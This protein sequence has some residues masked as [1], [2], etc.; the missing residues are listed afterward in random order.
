MS[1]TRR[2]DTHQ[3]H[4][5]DTK[6]HDA[7]LRI[8][9]MLDARGVTSIDHQG[10][11]LAA[12]DRVLLALKQRDTYRRIVLHLNDLNQQKDRDHG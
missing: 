9:R 5:L 6:S 12:T 8:H 10:R 4:E 7:V 11:Q 2:Q 3:R 1:A